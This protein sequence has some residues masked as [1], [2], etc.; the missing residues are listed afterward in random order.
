MNL[1]KDEFKAIAKEV[2]ACCRE[3]GTSSTEQVESILRKH[4]SQDG[5]VSVPEA[6]FRSYMT[7][8]LTILSEEKTGYVD[9]L[10][11]IISRAREKAVEAFHKAKT[12]LPTP[13]AKEGEA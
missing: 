10:H 4:A 12:P 3:H 5:W 2:V 7:T 11:S 1:S 6:W 8:V 9:Q 13:P